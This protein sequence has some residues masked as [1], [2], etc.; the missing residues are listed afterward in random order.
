MVLILIL[1]LSQQEKMKIRETKLL[2]EL[3]I[4]ETKY[5]AEAKLVSQL[6]ETISNLKQDHLL[7]KQHSEA[8]ITETKKKRL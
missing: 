2:E 7:I 3:S 4:S 6:K 1:A 8:E 5:K